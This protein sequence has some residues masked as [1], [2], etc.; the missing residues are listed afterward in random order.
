MRDKLILI[1]VAGAFAIAV[2]YVLTGRYETTEALQG[3]VV[4]TDRFS[5]EVVVCDGQTC[6]RMLA[7]NAT[8]T[9]EPPRYGAPAV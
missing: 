3:A 8:V 9:A 2:A 7:P 6:W 1:A 4:R 5:G